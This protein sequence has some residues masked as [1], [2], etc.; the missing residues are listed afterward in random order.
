MELQLQY[1]SSRGCSNLSMR[2]I[3]LVIFTVQYSI[4]LVILH[5]CFLLKP[6]KI[7]IQHMHLVNTYIRMERYEKVMG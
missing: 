1:R 6:L 7:I 4:I 5:S 3:S 2:M